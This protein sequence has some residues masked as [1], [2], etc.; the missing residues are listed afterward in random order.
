[1]PQM[2]K[3]IDM[4]SKIAIFLDPANL[5]REA[6]ILLLPKNKKYK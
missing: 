4:I 3:T 5:S 2:K 6:K 1:M